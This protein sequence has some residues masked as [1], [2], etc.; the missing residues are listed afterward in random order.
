[1]GKAIQAKVHP[2]LV[3]VFGN[4]A[5]SFADKIKNEYKLETLEVPNTLA[6]Q[7]LAAQ[8]RGRKII[9]FEIKKVGLNKGR[10]ILK[11]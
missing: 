11:R 4:I 5:R 8:Y 7:I 6:S 9:E 1:M 2:S 10:L 3:D